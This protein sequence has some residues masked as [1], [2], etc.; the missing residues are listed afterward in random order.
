MERFIKYLT[1]F[2]DYVIQYV[3][4]QRTRQDALIKY[5]AAQRQKEYENAQKVKAGID[6]IHAD[7]SLR[8][9][10]RDDLITFGRSQAANDK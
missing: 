7:P 3:R 6:N 1:V 8:N 10:L 4:D 5:Q 2:I 9:S